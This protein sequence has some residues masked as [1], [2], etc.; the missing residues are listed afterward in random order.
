MI[1]NA[2]IAAWAGS[3]VDNAGG[4][5][6]SILDTMERNYDSGNNEMKPDS[7]SYLGVVAAWG[8]SRVAGKAQKAYAVLRRMV[9]QYEK[10]GNESCRPNAQVYTALINAAAF[11][12]GSE[13]EQ[14]VAFDLAKSALDE[15]YDCKYD[16]V[17]SAAIGTFMKA[18]GRLKIPRA[19][20]SENLEISFNKCRELGLVNDFVLTQLRYS[21]PD[22]L[23]RRL[24]GDLI[25]SD[26]P[27]KVRVEVDKI[28]SEWRRRN[29]PGR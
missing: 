10:K 7:R 15:L 13:K 8:K 12:N 16:E 2:V 4:R 21:S 19:V 5:A 29:L 18:C 6:E 28:P 27:E 20:A 11:T 3:G 24:L 1:S 25:P 23:Y 9:L 22:G 26:G 14:R 17:T